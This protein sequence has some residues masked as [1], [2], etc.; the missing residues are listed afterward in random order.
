MNTKIGLT[1]IIALGIEATI[2]SQAKRNEIVRDSV[3]DTRDNRVYKMVKIGDKTWMSENLKWE[4]DGSYVYDDLTKKYLKK[5]GKLYSYDASRN[6][7]PTGTH[8]PSKQEWDTLVRAVDPKDKGDVGEKLIR[9]TNPGFAANMGGFRNAK[10]KYNDIEGSGYYWGSDNTVEI[11]S[12][13]NGVNLSVNKE[14]EK[15]DFKNFYSIRC[16]KD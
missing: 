12:V 3:V 9:K 13:M 11:K 4:C 14:I 1:V 16:V 6:A 7:C 5:Y 8:L 10:G 15:K 2:F